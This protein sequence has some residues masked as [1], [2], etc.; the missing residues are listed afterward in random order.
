[1]EPALIDEGTRKAK[2]RPRM[3]SALYRNVTEAQ[4]HHTPPPG[5]GLKWTR[6][7]RNRPPPSATP[8]TLSRQHALYLQRSTHRRDRGFDL[9]SPLCNFGF[10]NAHL[11]SRP[12]HSPRCVFWKRRL[13]P[14]MGRNV[15]ARRSPAVVTPLQPAWASRRGRA[16]RHCRALE[17]YL[18]V[19]SVL[20]CGT[21]RI[22]LT[23]CGDTFSIC[24]LSGGWI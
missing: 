2:P 14:R 3:G 6:L 9:R 7:L 10:S 24:E 22:V 23:D 18:D 8:S 17:S 12:S 11:H 4:E 1:M 13:C 15:R 16:K 21:H 19:S 5:A 20:T